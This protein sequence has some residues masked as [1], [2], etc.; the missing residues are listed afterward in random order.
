MHRLYVPPAKSGGSRARLGPSSIYK[1]KYVTKSQLQ[2][3]IK[4]EISDS[5]Y[6]GAGV[7]VSRR[8]KNDMWSYEGVGDPPR[9]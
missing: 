2:G 9:A 3:A 8:T 4:I 6:P 5:T 1:L 7:G